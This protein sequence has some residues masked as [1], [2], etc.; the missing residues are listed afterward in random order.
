MAW[1]L[2][3]DFF[4]FA[5][6]LK[7]CWNHEIPF[8]V[9]L[10][11]EILRLPLWGREPT[12]RLG[13]YLFLFYRANLIL[14]R[15]AVLSVRSLAEINQLGPVRFLVRTVV[16]LLHNYQCTMK[17]GRALGTVCINTI[18]LGFFSWNY[19]YLF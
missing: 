13:T 18:F 10:V 1:P 7:L 11:S 17:N 15:S 6:S 12:D 16:H 8:E 2:V 5:D 19:L 3:K 14:Y 9:G 4:F